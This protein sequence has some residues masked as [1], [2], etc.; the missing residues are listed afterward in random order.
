MQSKARKKCVILHVTVT[1]GRERL[2]LDAV[3]G[4]LALHEQRVHVF[5]PKPRKACLSEHPTIVFFRSESLRRKHRQY[6]QMCHTKGR[7]TAVCSSLGPLNTR[8]V[9]SVG[10]EFFT[11][12]TLFNLNLYVLDVC[13]TAFAS[14]YPCFLAY[15]ITLEQFSRLNCIY[16]MK[17]V[18]G[19]N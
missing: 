10:A 16:S 7:R 14:I 1:R 4:V 8:S 3:E 2:E 11:N 12:C 17:A 19:L 18:D 15:E 6:R 13:C 9:H 5:P